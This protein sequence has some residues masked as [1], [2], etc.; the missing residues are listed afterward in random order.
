MGISACTATLLL[1]RCGG[2]KTPIIP[3]LPQTQL[4]AGVLCSIWLCPPDSAALRDP[5]YTQLFLTPHSCSEG[6]LLYPG[7]L[8]LI[9][10]KR[11]LLYPPMS[12]MPD[13]C[14]Q[15]SLLYSWP[16]PHDQLHGETPVKPSC[17]PLQTPLHP[18]PCCIQQCSDSAALRNP[19]YTHLDKL[20]TQL[21]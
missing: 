7:L 1:P 13:N 4:H 19:C 15:V 17:G 10:V 2:R 21:H 18:G 12:P 8:S 5:C 16:Y 6:S 20:E 11:L 9:W 3:D 14:L